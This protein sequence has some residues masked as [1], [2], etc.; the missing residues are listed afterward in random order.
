MYTYTILYWKKCVFFYTIYT[1]G[2]VKTQQTQHGRFRGEWQQQQQANKAKL[3]AT[4]A[5]LKNMKFPSGG[6]WK[7]L[8]VAESGWKWLKVAESGR[9]LDTNVHD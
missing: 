9:I 7:W 5:K 3:D 2:K 8:K 4:L 6:G 1:H